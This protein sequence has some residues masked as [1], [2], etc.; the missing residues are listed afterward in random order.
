VSVFGATDF[1]LNH[2]GDTLVHSSIYQSTRQR[3][4]VDARPQILRGSEGVPLVPELSPCVAKFN[5]PATVGSCSPSPPAYWLNSTKRDTSP[6]F[7]SRRR[8]EATNWVK[9]TFVCWSPSISGRARDM[10]DGESPTIASALR[11]EGVPEGGVKHVVV[12]AR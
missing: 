12:G 4:R 9:G 8:V 7:N 6:A 11:C 10:G 2:D 5:T 3:N 1:T